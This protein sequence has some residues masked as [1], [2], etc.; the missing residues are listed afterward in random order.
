MA[1]TAAGVGSSHRH[2]LRSRKKLNRKGKS[3]SLAVAGV[4][5]TA[6]FLLASLIWTVITPN[7]PQAISGLRSNL[8]SFVQKHELAGYGPTHPRVVF[9]LVATSEGT[10]SNALELMSQ[11]VSSILSHTDRNRILSI[12]PVFEQ[13]AYTQADVQPIND[14]FTELNGGTSTHRHGDTTHVH[15]TNVV[16]HDHGD[17]IQVIFSD[18]VTVSVA[19]GRREAAQYAQR[20][21]T[22]YESSGLKSPE[23]DVLVVF[24]RPGSNIESA[25]WLDTVTNALAGSTSER[26]V[27]LSTSPKV[28]ETKSFNVELNP[29]HGVSKDT[30]TLLESQQQHPTP[31]VEGSVTAMKLDTFLH[32]PIVDD[33]LDTHY[34]ADLELS[35]NLWLCKDG[36]RLLEGAN[37]R[38]SPLDH[39]TSMHTS[40]LMSIDSAVR[41]VSTWM[42]GS[43]QSRFLQ[44]I[45]SQH[46][47]D[48]DQVKGLLSAASTTHSKVDEKCKTFEWF[49]SNI[50]PELKNAL[51]SQALSQRNKDLISTA[52]PVNLD[53]VDVTNGF[54][55][56]PHKG[57]MDENGLYG[58]VHDAS[59]LYKVH[60]EFELSD[61]EKT[62]GTKQDGTYKML[63]NKVFVDHESHDAAQKEADN[64]GRPRDKIFCLVYTIEENHDRL[65]PLLETWMPK[66]DG[67]MIASTK[68]DKELGTVNIPHEGPEEYN[69]IWQKVRSMWGYIYDNYYED[70]DWFHIGGDDLFVIVENLRLYLESEEIQLAANG[71]ET[72]PTGKETEQVP[73]FLGRRFKE[74]GNWDRVFNSGGSGYTMNKAALK[75]LVVNAFP[76]CMPHSKT[77]AEDV[78]VAQCFRNKLKVFPYD[79]KDEHG[80]ERY[81]PFAVSIIVSIVSLIINST[82]HSNID[83]YTILSH[84]QPAH[85][86]SYKI[87]KDVKSDWYANYSID[88]K[89]GLDHCAARSV[90]FH[91]IKGDLMKRMYAILYGYCK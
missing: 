52:K 60:P 14:K 47:V 50:D 13:D 32:L 40:K 91:Y 11:S 38:K 68:T 46:E 70:Y 62:C 59:A 20:L 57:A 49:A 7:P 6:L 78:M 69:N 10:N 29:V 72:L 2:K 18:S 82:S 3:N 53:Y 90:A 27:S 4:F 22:K 81:M 28:G 88:I 30:D 55:E 77:F 1:I 26:A 31:L 35:L 19:A 16:D 66:C 87:P 85:H 37:A 15:S 44:G 9:V 61:K 45:A 63:T 34:A 36:V 5:L 51:D 17:K 54:S 86:L 79:T 83:S 33:T 58:Y 84:P 25:D 21:V 48:L 80:G 56:H 41:F 76:T 8:S 71:G 42:N 65:P 74:Q 43:I 89:E 39:S 75:A 73:L 67:S 23:E 12:V 64:G 24:V